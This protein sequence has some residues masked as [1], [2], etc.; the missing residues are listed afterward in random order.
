MIKSLKKSTPLGFDSIYSNILLQISDYIVKPLT[1]LINLSFSKGIFPQVCK[2]SIISP[3]FKARYVKE[4]S[5]YRPIAL[6]SSI[7]KILEKY[8]KF[9]L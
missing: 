5:N 7:A 1:Y 9:H 3:I 6:I 4:L 2:N 8:A